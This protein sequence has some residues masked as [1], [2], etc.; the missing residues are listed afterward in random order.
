MGTKRE[1]R[2]QNLSILGKIKGII[3]LLTKEEI[4]MVC[5]D[6]YSLVELIIKLLGGK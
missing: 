5:L 3:F 1:C 2:E 6:A 4:K